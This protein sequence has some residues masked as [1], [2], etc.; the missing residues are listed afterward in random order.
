[1]LDAAQ[2]FTR[3]A[4][5]CRLEEAVGTSGHIVRS[6]GPSGGGGR[7][8]SPEAAGTVD[9]RNPAF[10]TGVGRASYMTYAMMYLP[11]DGS[12]RN[13]GDEG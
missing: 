11:V 9:V 10:I 5:A 6:E 1:M 7:T 12:K 2:R 3:K 4:G 13:R 8:G